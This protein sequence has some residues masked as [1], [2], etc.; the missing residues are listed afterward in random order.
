VTLPLA[1]F[2]PVWLF[3]ALN[4]LSPGPNVLNTMTTA[5]GSGRSAGLASACGV[6]LGIGLWCLAMSLGMAT[7]FRVAPGA[8]TVLTL[9]AAGLLVWFGTRFLRAAFAS[10]ATREAQLRAQAGLTWRG[11]F[12]RSLSINATN[13][14]ALTTW[15]VILG[16][17]P[18]ASAGPGD[19]ALLTL[20]ACFLSLS[21]HSV[22]A[23]LFST[24]P[25]ARLYLRAAPVING[26]VGLF[27]L[28]FAVKLL[29]GLL[30]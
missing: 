24:R 9:I 6:G 14:K 2:L 23:A 16:L 13:P 17:F 26:G 29:V 25:A 18:T 21:I 22:Y 4:I 30:P 5:M 3:L 7:L 10:G 1:V 28:G 19:I 11:A 8:Q 12:L 20:G 27:F 15:T